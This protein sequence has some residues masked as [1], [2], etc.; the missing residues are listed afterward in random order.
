VTAVVGGFADNTTRIGSI[1]QPA[2]LARHGISSAKAISQ[3][4]RA[5]N[6]KAALIFGLQI[7]FFKVVSMTKN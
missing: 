6:C 7:E 5:F 2:A 1:S 4:G 3:P